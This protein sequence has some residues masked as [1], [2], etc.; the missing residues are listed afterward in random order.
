MGLVRVDI[1]FAMRGKDMN[2]PN[3]LPSLMVLAGSRLKNIHYMKRLVSKIALLSIVFS[4][5]FNLSVAPVAASGVVVTLSPSSSSSFGAPGITE[6]VTWTRNSASTTQY[7]TSTTITVTITPA[8]TSVSSSS[9]I[10]LDQ[11][12]SNDTTLTSTSTD[13][14]STFATFTVAT[15]TAVSSTFSIPLTGF[16][17]SSTAQ[18][19]SISIFSSNPVDFGSALFYANGGNQVS[20][21]AS[22]PAT[23]SFS[24]R[25]SADSATTNS[26]SLGTLST[27]ATS[28]CSYRLRIQTNAASGFAATIKAN[29][30][31]ATGSATITQVTNDTPATAGTEAYG[32]GTLT[33]ATAG[34]RNGSTG[35]FDQPVTE[36]GGAGAATTTF[37]TDPSPVPTTTAVTIIS[38]TGGF[39]VSS[40][41][42]LTGTSLV[43]HSATISGG[44][45]AG[46]YTQTVTYLVTA[47]Y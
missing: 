27:S 25:N 10:D 31:L 5:M 15:T 29:Q 13:G 46:N 18:N 34:G 4:S 8:I 26:C 12:G 24:I 41:P 9:A 7:V 21:T 47:T 17:F 23:L 43:T 30:D 28:T 14:S 22:V 35:A 38:Y 19:Y 11:S 45:P 33:G 6:T 32:I 16:T 36:G 44:T 20:V 3:G 40:T 39:S 1:F 2:L 42:S 37:S